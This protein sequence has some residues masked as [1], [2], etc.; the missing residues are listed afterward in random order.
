M[1]IGIVL[2]LMGLAFGGSTYAWGEAGNVAPLVIGITSLIALGFWEWKGSKDPF[3]AHELFVGRFRTFTLMLVITF[4]GGMS[5]YTAMAFW[6][7]Q[8][9]GMFFRDPM[10]IGV[11]AI[12]GG[13]GGTIGGFLGGVLVGKFKAF[14]IPY[15]LVLANVIKLIADAVFTTLKPDDY[16]LALGMG[17]IAMFG[18]GMS[19]V[20]LI[21][22]VQLTCEDKNIGLATLVLGS[23]RAIGGSVA[24]T[25]YTTILQNTI[26][27]DAGPRIAAAVVPLGVPIDSLADFI[28][29]LVG[30]RED[31]AALV[32]GVS[33]EALAVAEETIKYTWA[34]AF[35]H[36][37]YAA[38]SFSIL[39]IVASAFVRD[40]TGNMTDSV[41][42]RLENDEKKE[43]KKEV[44]V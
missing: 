36:I 27:Q 19:L 43:E 42:V 28:P 35:S 22:G 7:Q 12:P 30:A 37:Y 10:K 5:L 41:A 4:V 32:P 13:F 15:M 29:L 40:V 16:P 6:T 34:K 14:K 26:A 17:F 1:A 24:I 44:D 9:Q 11:S 8:C 25:I 23:V 21:V 20:A 39:A 38:M 3:F 33:A 18:M 31:L 2:T